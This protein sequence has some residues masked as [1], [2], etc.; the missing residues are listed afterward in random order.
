MRNLALFGLAFVL[1]TLASC[2]FYLLDVQTFRVDLLAIFTF[3]LARTRRLG[4]ALMSAVFLGLLFA[5]FQH[6]A[7]LYFVVHAVTMILVVRLASRYLNLKHPFFVALFLFAMDIGL[8]SLMWAV[9][10]A[11]GP[12]SFSQQPTLVR[13]ILAVAGMTA[14]LAPWLHILMDFVENRFT[15]GSKDDLY[16][17]K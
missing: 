2:L 13:R 4:D 3:Y 9:A 5:F 12:V 10:Q 16:L 8:Q 15:L 11:T 7:P 14:L 17:L 6:A 1:F